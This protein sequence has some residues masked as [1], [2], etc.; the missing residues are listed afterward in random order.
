MPQRLSDN[1]T[2]YT[3]ATGVRGRSLNQPGN[4]D[5]EQAISTAFDQDDAWKVK[6]IAN[7]STQVTDSTM[8]KAPYTKVSSFYLL[9]VSH[10]LQK[11]GQETNWME[12]T[13]PIAKQK[14]FVPRRQKPQSLETDEAVGKAFSQL[15]SQGGTDGVIIDSAPDDVQFP[16][17]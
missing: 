7:E 13:D 2:R 11:F 17:V 8:G 6:Q 4:V 9:G 14:R 1:E 12:Q 5:S 3:P 15:D 16:T 10:A